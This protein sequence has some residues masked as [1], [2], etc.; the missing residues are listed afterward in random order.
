MPFK[1]LKQFRTCY[2]TDDPNWDCDEWLRETKSLCYLD[3]KNKPTKAKNR[4][5][6]KGPFVGPRGGK[7]LLFKEYNR[8]NKLV[9][10][11]KVYI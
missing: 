11:K 7:F 2:S 4:I 5:V 9:C 3:N 8:N 6:K 10:T 1:S